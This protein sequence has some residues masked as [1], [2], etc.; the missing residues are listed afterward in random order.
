MDQIDSVI[1]CPTDWLSQYVVELEQ[2]LV[3]MLNHIRSTVDWI[4]DGLFLY[5]VS[6]KKYLNTQTVIT[7]KRI[8]S[9]RGK[10]NNKRE[11]DLLLVPTD[12]HST[13]EGERGLIS[14]HVHYQLV[15]GNRYIFWLLYLVI[16]KSPK[17]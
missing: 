1:L 2:M 6:H 17:K 15:H 12:V 8:D 9:Y 4:G 5:R 7:P 16:S 3:L 11:R 14:K 13:A 10:N